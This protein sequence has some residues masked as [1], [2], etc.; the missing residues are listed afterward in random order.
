VLIDTL[1]DL[2][3]DRANAALEFLASIATE[4]APEIAAGTPPIKLRAAWQTWFDDH[5]AKLDLAARLDQKDQG[6]TV[7]ACAN[8]G[9]NSKVYEIDRDGAVRWHFEGLRQPMDVQV[10]GRNR[11]LVTEDLGRRVTERDFE[12][13]ILW[14]RP[15]LMP[16]AAE[17]LPNGQTFIATR[18]DLTVIDREGREIFSWTRPSQT[19]VA[20]RRLRDGS[21]VAVN[22]GGICQV[23]DPLGREMKSFR[24]G[25]LYT[26]G[27]HIDVL[28]NGRI[29]MAIMRESR[30]VEYDLD[31]QVH[32]QAK[33]QNPVSASRLA[34]GNTLVVTNQ[35]RVVELS[36]AGAEVW[37]HA[38]QGRA[39]RARRR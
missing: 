15:A 21:M 30:V 1:A 36:P 8:A 17:R 6:L 4:Q 14:E 26:I 25:Q 11:V 20:A 22:S 19:I 34:N 39:W 37:S 35:S 23:I 2:P 29:V 24:V 3:G 12:G 38:T 32:W 13:K 9:V 18:R 31:G 28:P 7:I 10:I 16:I 33:V 5:G 27:S